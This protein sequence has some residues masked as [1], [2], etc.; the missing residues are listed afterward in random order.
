MFLTE[1]DD[2]Q[3]HV[4][5]RSNR[6]GYADVLD[7]MHRHRGRIF[8]ETLGWN[9]PGAGDGQETDPYDTPDTVYLVV[10][11]REGVLRGSARFLPTMEPFMLG[12]PLAHFADGPVPTGP[13]IWEW[14]RHAPGDPA[15]PPEVNAQARLALHLGVMEWALANGISAFVAVMETWLVRRA[16]ALGW[17]CLPLGPPRAYA[18]GEAIAVLNPVRAETLSDLR[19]KHGLSGPALA[20]GLAA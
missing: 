2:V 14:S 16:Q 11:D 6:D 15:A 19:K 17:A 12:G 5:G 13:D 20:Q 4:I 18:E 7:A 9:I 1:V 3:V 8:V 10:L